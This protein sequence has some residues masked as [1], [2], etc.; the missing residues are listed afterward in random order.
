MNDDPQEV[1]Q[2]VSYLTMVHCV[3]AVPSSY[4]VGLRLYFRS[5]RCFV[6]DAGEGLTQQELCDACV[7]L[8]LLRDKRLTAG[9]SGGG[10]RTVASTEPTHAAWA[11]W[12]AGAGAVAG[13]L[14]PPD[15]RPPSPSNRHIYN[16]NEASGAVQQPYIFVAD[17]EESFVDQENCN[18]DGGTECGRAVRGTNVEEN[19]QDDNDRN[20]AP[21]RS[22]GRLPW[23]NP[24]LS[25]MTASN[26]R[27]GAS[28]IFV[29]PL[30]HW[31][32][33]HVYTV[34]VMGSLSCVC[35]KRCCYTSIL[36]VI[37]YA[38]LAGERMWE[39]QTLPALF[40]PAAKI[41]GSEF[42]NM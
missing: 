25:Q 27:I 28:S 34:V 8:V 38:T 6:Y 18:F 20:V 37:D 12:A 14:S 26:C 42:M 11:A 5:L 3:T 7:S 23:V 39:R 17:R 4:A 21:E 24:Y 19:G 30:C 40:S 9:G 13:V 2:A 16:E 31:C 15:H 41:C 22:R 35:R 10:T 29:Y 32:L 33:F 1:R 36:Q